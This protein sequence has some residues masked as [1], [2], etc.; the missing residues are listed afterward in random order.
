MIVDIDGSYREDYWVTS[1]GFRDSTV[2]V[3]ST[4][5]YRDELYAIDSRIGFLDNEIVY[6]RES[7]D[8]KPDW[9]EVNAHLA[10]DC[11]VGSTVIDVGYTGADKQFFHGSLD[12]LIPI[13]NY[14]VR[15]HFQ[16]MNTD[17][18][19]AI[20]GLS[21]CYGNDALRLMVGT[22]YDSDEEVSPWLGFLWHS[23]NRFLISGGYEKT[24]QAYPYHRWFDPLPLRWK[25][26]K[27]P[28][29][30]AQA[31]MNDR[32]EMG[33]EFHAGKTRH[34]LR[35]QYD[36]GDTKYDVDWQD[37]RFTIV[38]V[39]RSLDHHW[40]DYSF[41]WSRFEMAYRWQDDE[42]FEFDPAHKVSAS[43]DRLIVPF[44]HLGVL[45]N[46]QHDIEI[47]DESFDRWE[48][49]ASVSYQGVQNWV[50]TLRGVLCSDDL[51]ESE[52]DEKYRLSVNIAY[53]QGEYERLH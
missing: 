32:A 15:A 17:D 34:E 46:W 49:G 52:I 42:R 45:G 25:T 51:P 18:H 13:D 27:K 16:G 37:D 48:Y 8:H 1:I 20:A 4:E 26:S 22:N 7:W 47:R 33:V 50:F 40:V 10:F 6:R 44:V 31:I 2:S 23:G 11:P 29:D 28:E 30:T 5:R 35:W 19:P 36:H 3:K 38:H 41:G 53:R 21:L 43:W 14:A 24:L 9:N 39:D 12:H